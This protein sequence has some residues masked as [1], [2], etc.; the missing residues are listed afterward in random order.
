MYFINVKRRILQGTSALV[1]S[2]PQIAS[3]DIEVTGGKQ[4]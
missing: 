4:P 3:L 1:I 2:I